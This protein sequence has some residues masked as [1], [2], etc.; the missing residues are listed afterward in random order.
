MFMTG[1]IGIPGSF[2][3]GAQGLNRLA[4]A[5]RN[6]FVK[7]SRG[8]GTL[9]R[10]KLTEALT[11]GSHAAA[12]IESWNGSAYANQRD[13]TVYDEEPGGAWSGVV[14]D[15]GWCTGRDNTDGQF[16]IIL[17]GP[18]HDASTIQQS[19]ID[20]FDNLINSQ[21]S[22]VDYPIPVTLAGTNPECPPYG[23]VESISSETIN[24]QAGYTVRRPQSS[25]YVSRYLVVNQ[26]GLS[27]GT[28]GFATWLER[29][30]W[31]A[32]DQ[33]TLGTIADYNVNPTFGERML[34]PTFGTYLLGVQG[35]DFLP[36][37][38]SKTVLDRHN[39]TVYVCRAKQL[40]NRR[41]FLMATC[42]GV[43]LAQG[44]YATMAQSF[45]DVAEWRVN[46][47]LANANRHAKALVAGTYQFTLSG[48]ASMT[49]PPIVVGGSASLLSYRI[50]S[51]GTTEHNLG[52]GSVLTF[53]TVKDG[54]GTN[55]SL[56]DRV[57]IH[58]FVQ[59]GAGERLGFKVSTLDGG[60]LNPSARL[61][62]GGILQLRLIDRSTTVPFGA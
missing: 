34:R 36:L 12:S 49:S 38:D 2:C 31:V 14:G 48:P 32:Y 22:S 7:M 42:G 37:G 45:S 39:N 23:I 18:K 60:P 25:V 19:Y 58:G 8:T 27:A 59:L 50:D 44:D 3:E 52:L 53:A 33:A 4:Q 62:F 16:S 13:G 54:T 9:F 57:L 56:P 24:G 1:D 26:D 41:A 10:F 28:P 40:F 46:F 29:S 55:T 43:S 20:L 35:G 15:E 30:A 47:T 11:A 5:V 21:L 17:M 51:D 6:N 61:T